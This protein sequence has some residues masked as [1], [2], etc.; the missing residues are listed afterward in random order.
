MQETFIK[1]NCE[2]KSHILLKL[3]KHYVPVGLGAKRTR[4]N[5]D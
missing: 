2:L 1:C 5:V 3:V 4:T